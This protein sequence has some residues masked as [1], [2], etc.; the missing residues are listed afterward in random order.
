[1][2]KYFRQL[3]LM[4][5]QNLKFQQE[6]VLNRFQEFRF[7]QIVL[8]LQMQFQHF[9]YIS[10]PIPKIRFNSINNSSINPHRTMP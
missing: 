2:K 6:F 10:L 8:S 1:M 4:E 9:K 3:W 7:Q 5:I